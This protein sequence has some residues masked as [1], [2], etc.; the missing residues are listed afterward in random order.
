MSFFDLGLSVGA[1]LKTEFLDYA[2]AAILLQ[3]DI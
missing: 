1:E 3:Q 2:Q